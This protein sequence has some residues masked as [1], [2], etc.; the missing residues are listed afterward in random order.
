MPVHS[1]C[2]HRKASSKQCSHDKSV[3]HAKFENGCI[4]YGGGPKRTRFIV[5]PSPVMFSGLKAF[6]AVTLHYHPFLQLTVATISQLS[7]IP[8]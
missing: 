8:S 3:I 5:V 1:S 4:P 6:D 7:Y 2:D